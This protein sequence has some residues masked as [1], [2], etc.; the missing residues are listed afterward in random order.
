M[1]IDILFERI[2]PNHYFISNESGSNL[3]ISRD[4]FSSLLSN[5]LAPQL[6]KKLYEKNMIIT[7]KNEWRYLRNYAKLKSFTFNPP[8]LHIVVLTTKCNHACI[9]CRVKPS[10]NKEIDMDIKTAFKVVDFILSTPSRYITIEFQG[11]ESLINWKTFEKTIEYLKEKQ[12]HT[13]KEIIV[14]VVTNLSLMTNE[15]LKF[16]LENNIS[17]CTSLDGPR[18]I[19]NTNRIYSATDSYEMVVKWLKILMNIVQKLKSGKRDSLPSALMTT[20]R[21]SL[22]YPKEIIDEYRNLHLGG[23]F[24]RPLSPIGYAAS[25]WDKIGYSAEE[26]LEFYEESLDYILEINKTE[27]FIERNA[28][29]K[30][31]KILLNEDPNYLDLRS[32]CGAVVGQ[33]SYYP[34]GGIYTCDEGRMVGKGGEKF[35]KIGNVFKNSYKDILTSIKS[36]NVVYSSLNDNYPKCIRCAFKP[37]CGICPV[38]N[39]TVKNTLIN[40]DY[41]NLWCD[42]EKG[43]FKILI[44]K[45]INEKHRKIFMRWFDA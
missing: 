44:K 35:F 10:T 33:I 11:G 30:L 43:I 22:K 32:P 20:T 45:I 42:I 19:H 13:S 24:I 23:I 25:V 3:I 15:K 38:F 6:I 7:K 1:K 16:I 28:A 21:I 29:I 5:K 14:S 31:K 2:D 18:H 8:S 27:K 12:K 39:Y 26:F 17:V 9:Y 41:S 34:D 40:L 4:E 37:F 36:R